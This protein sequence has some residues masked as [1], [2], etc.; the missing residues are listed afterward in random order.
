MKPQRRLS[1]IFLAPALLLAAL[2]APPR[3]RAEDKKP[4]AKPAAEPAKPVAE[5]AKPSGETK[6]SLV[7]ASTCI[8]CH[9]ERDNFHRNIHAKAMPK[10]KGI[11]FEQ[12]C[13]TCHGPGSLHAG[14]GGDK[15][16]PDFWTIKSFKKMKSSEVA[17]TCLQCHSGGKRMHW[18]GSTHEA[19]GVSCVQCHSL[20]NETVNGGKAPLLT[21]AV[22]AEVCYQCHA[23]K[24]AQI[25]K[26]AHMP[27]VEGQMGCTACHNPHGSPGEKLLTK[28]SVPET[29]Y[30]CHQDKRGPFLYEHPPVRE[31]CRNCHD[32]H[33]S[34]NDFALVAKP[35]LLCQRCHQAGTGHPASDYDI[36]NLN[37]PNNIKVF[38]QGCVNCHNRI[39]GSNHPGG[40]KFFLR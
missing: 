8:S 31:D 27:L 29:C 22:P 21:K 6:A 14:A 33:G 10:E 34:H 3:V 28:S 2:L 36:S 32:P 4:E 24:K 19:K 16:N 5:T 15:S 20:H 38:S 11:Q 26:S 35:P 37:G 17:E 39:H 9:A 7:G 23:E 18:E 30:Q 25:R 12:T 40:G 13:E 1:A